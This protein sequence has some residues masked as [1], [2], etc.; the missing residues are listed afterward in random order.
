M[1]DPWVMKDPE[2][3][4]WLMFFTAR[5]S[6]I[7]GRPAGGP[8]ASPPRPTSNLDAPA[9]VFT[10]GYGQLEVPRCFRRAASGSGSLPAASI[11]RK[12]GAE[13]TEGGPVTWQHTTL[14]AAQPARPWTIAP[15]FL[16]GALPPRR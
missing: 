2:S 7:A 14:M 15:G 4:G 13:A 9:P 3:D 16:D 6:G 12:S 5:A 11:S 1:R 10:G 8:S